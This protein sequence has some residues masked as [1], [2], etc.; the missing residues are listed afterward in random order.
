VT[1]LR[2]RWGLRVLVS[3]LVMGACTWWIGSSLCRAMTNGAR[4]ITGRHIAVIREALENYAARYGSYPSIAET[5]FA[6]VAPRLSGFTTKPLPTRDG[7]G[8]PLAIASSPHHWV[9]SSFGRDGRPDEPRLGGLCVS[10]N[11][12]LIFT[13]LGFWQ[14]TPEWTYRP[15]AFNP[16]GPDP[17]FV[18]NRE[19]RAAALGRN[20]ASPEN[21]TPRP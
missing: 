5:E 8:H 6:S 9:V 1:G 7:W 14:I 12:D 16:V 11:C 4:K 20:G 17:L 18:I 3:V 15:G 10:P 2:S 19:L 13:E 21:A